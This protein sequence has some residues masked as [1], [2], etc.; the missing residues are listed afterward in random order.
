L[1][2]GAFVSE[3]TLQLDSIRTLGEFPDT[4]HETS[5]GVSDIEGMYVADKSGQSI[6]FIDQGVYTK[7]RN[8]RI[9]M[10]SKLGKG[11]PLLEKNAVPMTLERFSQMLVCDDTQTGHL[12]DMKCPPV[13]LHTSNYARLKSQN[14]Q[15]ASAEI[16][17]PEIE[18]RILGHLR[19]LQ[20]DEPFIRTRLYKNRTVIYG[21]GNNRYCFNVGREHQS[22]GVYYAVDLDRRVF[23]QRCHDPD[24]TNFVSN[25]FSIG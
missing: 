22:N 1:H 17:Y 6:L 24:C 10:S 4:H 16:L 20:S 13:A 21:I 25:E 9:V 14:V 23:T 7:N 8:M 5:L 3:L 12:I 19:R 2:V 15:T 11:V 18:A